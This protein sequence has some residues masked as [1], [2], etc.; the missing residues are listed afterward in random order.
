IWPTRCPG[1]ATSTWA[2]RAASVSGSRIRKQAGCPL[3]GPARVDLAI[4]KP[5]RY[6][7]ARPS[8]VPYCGRIFGWRVRAP[9]GDGWG[10]GGGRRSGERGWVWGEGGG[11]GRQGQS[12]RRYERGGSSQSVEFAWRVHSALEFWTAKVD[13]KASIL[14]AFQGGGFIFAATSRE[15]IT[16]T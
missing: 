2:D 6:I 12:V 13:M 3:Y 1:P 9:G 16:S 5:G 8:G 15:M 7:D 10:W 11:R 14:L 4:R